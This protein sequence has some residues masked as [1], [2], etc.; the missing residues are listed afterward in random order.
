MSEHHSSIDIKV[1]QLV[2]EDLRRTL[3]Q[4]AAEAMMMNID[5]ESDFKKKD[6]LLKVNDEDV[7]W[8]KTESAT[9]QFNAS[10]LDN[11]WDLYDLG[12]ESVT[13]TYFPPRQSQGKEF[14]ES[15]V[16][17]MLP[18]AGNRKAGDSLAYKLQLYEPGLFEEVDIVKITTK[19][20]KSP[21][22]GEATHEDIEHLQRVLGVVYRD[23]QPTLATP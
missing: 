16:I 20:A 15:V 11:P 6:T 5:E 8:Q 18:L 13:L 12:V 7:F 23:D 3:F 9:H 4:H 21:V 1:Q 14:A 10:E 2:D 19:N 17:D 22:V